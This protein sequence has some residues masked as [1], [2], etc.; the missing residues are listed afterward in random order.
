MALSTKVSSAGRLAIRSRVAI[1][2]VRCQSDFG[3]DS[4]YGG[5]QGGGAPAGY[6]GEQGGRG[7]YGGGR[8]QPGFGGQQ[9]GGFGGQQG[10]GFG[11]Q[12]GGGFGGQ[13]GGGFGGQQ[14]GGFGGPPGGFGGRGGGRGGG[15]GGPRQ[16]RE[17]MPEVPLPEEG[18]FRLFLRNLNYDATDQD[19][20]SFFG[21]IEVVDV[22][23]PKNEF[24]LSRGFGFVEVATRE[25]AQKCL[26]DL[27]GKDMLGRNIHVRV[28]AARAQTRGGGG[29]GA[30]GGF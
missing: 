25:D 27:D 16:P 14:G 11:G 26:D 13:P 15:F 28:A 3:D 7:G 21:D 23:L 2:G 6:G 20:R 1:G 5:G 29:G 9:G 22:H 30:Q 10:G 24:G 19:M 4:M 17:P 12:Q 18:P 8:Q